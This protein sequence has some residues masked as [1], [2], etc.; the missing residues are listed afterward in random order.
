MSLYETGESNG[1][2]SLIDLFNN[3]ED[4][5]TCRSDLSVDGIKFAICR[6]GWPRTLNINSDKAKLQIAKELFN[7]T[8]DVDIS[9]IDIY[10][11]FYFVVH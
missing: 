2:V 10:Q 3:K 1:T 8:C 6:G 4:F 5:S 11:V 7:Q 9:S